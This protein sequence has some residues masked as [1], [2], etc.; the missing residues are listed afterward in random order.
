VHLTPVVSFRGL[1]PSPSLE[2]YIRGRIEKL[3]TYYGGIIGCRVLVELSHRH[4]ETGNRYHVRIDITVPG[5]ELVVVHAASLH[6]AA[7]DADAPKI[8]RAAETD[9][10]RKHARVAVR[11]AFDVARRRLQDYARRQRG[12]VKIAAR[13]PHG[14]VVQLSPVDEYG[15]I[16][17]A[18]GHEVYFQKSS[19]LRSDF[20]R[21][22]VGSRVSFVE[23]PGDK[24]P[25]ASTVRLMH[26]RRARQAVGTP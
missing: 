11:E 22:T 26:P 20:D 14:R 4:H 7:Q 25:Q 18:D 17:A 9:P 1:D 19:V 16:E 12:T 3:E 6:A 21:L 10:G 15:Y 8:S 2:A 23:E 13:Q 5:E 24:G